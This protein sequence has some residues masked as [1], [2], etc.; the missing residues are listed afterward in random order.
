MQ[1]EAVAHYLGLL[2]FLFERMERW[3]GV[4]EELA[5]ELPEVA[6]LE[7][8]MPGIGP[9][10]SAT[11]AAELGPIQRFTSPKA[12]ARFTGLTPSER[13]S[14]GKAR[15]GSI[16]REGSEH[17]RWALTQAAMAC[18]RSRSGAGLAAGNW[19][20]A[21]EKR[22]GCKAKARVAGARKLAE[23]I[24]RLFNWGELF[25][26]SKPFGGVPATAR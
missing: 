21:K 15:Q 26:A 18:L 2:E 14:A 22:M 11:I 19:I 7:R 6:V 5:A 24:W 8:E 9:V 25:D 4:I 17:L 10:L 1:A 16:T 23:S 12:L 13:S 20:R 3:E